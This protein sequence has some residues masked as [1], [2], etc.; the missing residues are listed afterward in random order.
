MSHHSFRFEYPHKEIPLILKSV[1]KE[2]LYFGAD[3]F[4]S[5]KMKII[6]ARYRCQNNFHTLPGRIS[7][8]LFPFEWDRITRRF[9]IR[10]DGKVDVQ[11]NTLEEMIVNQA[12]FERV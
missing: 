5:R 9:R 2:D 11:L 3:L 12:F 6:M 7:V 8:S 4:E 1:Y 10:M